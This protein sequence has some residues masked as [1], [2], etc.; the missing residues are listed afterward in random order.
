MQ[1]VSAP[2][3]PVVQGSTVYFWEWPFPIKNPMLGFPFAKSHCFFFNSMYLPT[4]PNM[5]DKFLRTNLY[6][7][8]MYENQEIKINFKTVKLKT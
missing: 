1:E 8:L 3:S 2:N 4:S 7:T 6:S 5:R